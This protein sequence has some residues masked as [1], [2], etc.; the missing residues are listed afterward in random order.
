MPDNL[1][2]LIVGAGY[3]AKEYYKV[4]KT[5]DIIPVVIGRGQQSASEFKKTTGC[6]VST[7]DIS[8]FL[9]GN[10]ERFSHA[11]VAVDVESLTEVTIQ[12]I[13]NGINQILVEK[14]AG[15]NIFELERLAS[16]A[17]K[18]NCYLQV[19]YNRRYYSSV[20]KANEIIEQDGGVTTF[21][22]EFTEW[23]HKISQLNKSDVCK[24]AWFLA[25]SSHIID[26][27]FYIGGFPEKMVC[28]SR[29]KLSWHPSG[30]MYTGAGISDRGALFSYHANWE[31]PGRW[32]I[33][34]VTKK[35][36]LIFKP[37]ET[38]MIQVIGSNEIHE[39]EISGIEIDTQYK[40]GLFRMVESF[41]YK[42]K[43]SKVV[44][45]QDQIENVKIYQKM[46]LG[47]EK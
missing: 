43:D 13:D 10:K 12:L 29:G 47:N 6:E 38:L 31:G 40:P 8:E 16:F 17:Q 34:I 46:Y 11:I 27:A 20:A 30:S 3:M 14:P 26:M 32:S 37:L 39:V 24:N 21:L 45:I 42:V 19:A 41:L 44:T 33:E 4:L 5:M 9:K 28:Y 22:F 36:R 1:N 25:N 2:I 7:I 18:E 23:S 35:H 15:L